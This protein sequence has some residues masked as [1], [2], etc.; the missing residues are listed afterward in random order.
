M[1]IEGLQQELV[2]PFGL[3]NAKAPRPWKCRMQN[4]EERHPAPRPGLEGIPRAARESP[5]P[6]TKARGE[7]QG[8]RPFSQG[9]NCG[10]TALGLIW[11]RFKG[12]PLPSPLPA[13]PSR[14]EGVSAWREGW[15]VGQSS[16]D[17][18][19][20]NPLS[21]R[22][23]SGE[24]A[25]ERG[26]FVLLISTIETPSD[27]APNGEPQAQGRRCGPEPP[28]G[29]IPRRNFSEHYSCYYFL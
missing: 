10:T 20:T 25:R 3:G 27:G 17:R 7:G 6:A 15:P 29:V 4:G 22:G 19:P 9:V 16:S 1:F 28:G 21:P 18:P 12:T 13:R 11:I 23:T 26:S 8:A 2:I 24:R 14:G 5:R